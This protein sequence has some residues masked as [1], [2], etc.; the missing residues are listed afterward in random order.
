MVVLKMGVDEAVR[1]GACF[2]AH[3]CAE[4][5]LP[6]RQRQRSSS[7]WKWD[8]TAI[9]TPIARE[10][11]RETIVLAAPNCGLLNAQL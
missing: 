8:R 5:R 7:G 10:L 3:E 6:E 2:H 1:M 9:S 11:P 4:W